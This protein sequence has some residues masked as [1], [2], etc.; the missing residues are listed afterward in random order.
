MAK[1][2]AASNGPVATVVE[3]KRGLSKRGWG[4]LL[5]VVLVL[6]AVGTGVWWWMQRDDTP[7]GTRGTNTSKTGKPAPKTIESAYAT[8]NYQ[9]ALDMAKSKA[10]ADDPASQLVLAAAYSNNKQYDEAYKIYDTLDAQGKLSGQDTMAAGELA[11]SQGN[12]Q[13]AISYYEKA[14]TKLEKDTTNRYAPRQLNY[15]TKQLAE[16]QK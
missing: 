10:K 3:T 7:S 5:I 6:A 4:V 9:A 1:K 16:L 15:V 12:K 2:S 14:K 13:K 11:Q 8:G